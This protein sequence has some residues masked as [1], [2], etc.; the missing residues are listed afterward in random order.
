MP[1]ILD[2]AGSSWIYPV[3]VFVE[4]HFLRIMLWCVGGLT[5]VRHNAWQNITAEWLSGIC[6]DVSIEPPLQPLTGETFEP[7]TANRQDEAIHA[8]GFWGQRQSAFLDIRVFHPNAPSYCN[9][10][11]TSLYRHHEAQKKR[12][13]GER[14]R[15][16]E[17]ASF[18]PLVFSTTR[19]M[20]RE[21]IVFYRC[22]ADH[23]SHCGSTSYSQTLAFIRCTLSFSLLRS[24][25]MCIHGSRSISHCSSD[26]SPEMGCIHWDY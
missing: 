2:M 22:L 26:A 8:R 15:E 1:C 7:K 14:V 16:V 11:I 21:A 9:T 19:G 13:Y 3:T 25:T 10:S 24:A 4:F 6:H 18:T 12:E 20:G 23:L 5:L 17:Q